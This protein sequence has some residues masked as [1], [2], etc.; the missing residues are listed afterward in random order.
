[1]IILDATTKKIE[2][3]LG[4]TVTTNQLPFEASYVDITTTTFTPGSNDGASNN[5]TAVIVVDV[6]GASTQRQVKIINI[7]NADTVA[8]TVTVRY[9]NN[10][11][12]RILVKPTLAVGD[13]LS[14]VDGQGWFT[15]DSNGNTKMVATQGPTGPTG[16][17]GATGPLL[18]FASPLTVTTTINNTITYTTGGVTLASQTL[19]SGSV[20]RIK[21]QGT[22]TAANSTTTRS[23][24]AGPFWGSSQLAT[25]SP[26]V[27]TSTAATTNWYAEIL[28]VGMSTTSAFI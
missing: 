11:T 28:I 8:T 14:Y 16:P 19:A 20:W 18:A 4:G 3:L 12:T 15:V 6:P 17:T 27:K 1:M 13:T 21:A 26:A 2:F 25:F 9:N 10:G 23:A 24:Q 7:Y 5:T 22:F